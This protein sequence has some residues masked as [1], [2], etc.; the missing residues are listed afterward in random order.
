[1]YAQN[2]WLFDLAR[3]PQAIRLLN[4]RFHEANPTFSLDGK[5]LAFT[6]DESGR[7][8]LYLQAFR[9]GDSPSLVGERLLVSSA[10][11]QAV[12]WRRDG[13]ELFYLEDF[14]GRVQA[15][16][17]GSHRNCSSA[18]PRP[19]LRSLPK[20]ELPFTVCLASMCWPIAN[21][22]SFRS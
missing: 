2:V 19:F 6:S 18:P 13:T 4:T 21:A 11:A 22:L 12:R 7:P 1:M 10:G 14:D 3:R 15:V 17:S 9:S 8:E 20:R 16:P 5:W